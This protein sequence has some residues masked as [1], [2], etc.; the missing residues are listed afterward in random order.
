M[1][2][3]ALRMRPLD[4]SQL[5]RSLSGIADRHAQLRTRFTA[6]GGELVPVVDRRPGHRLDRPSCS[7]ALSCVTGPSGPFLR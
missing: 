4:T 1:L 5:E 7:L 2:P 3:L 6:V